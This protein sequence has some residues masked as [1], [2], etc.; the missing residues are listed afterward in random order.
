MAE[1]HNHGTTPLIWTPLESLRMLIALAWARRG[2][3]EI[4]CNGSLG[5]WVM[6]GL[7]GKARIFIGSSS[8]GKAAAETTASAL[9][10]AGM[11]PLLWSDFFKTRDRPLQELERRMVD[12]DGA[13][14]VGSADDRLV[15]RDKEYDQ[16]R[17]NVLF[18]YGLFAGRLGRHRCVLLMP[19]HPRFRI[20]SDFLGVVGFEFYTD[21]TLSAVAK[22]V[23]ERLQAA[24]AA[25]GFKPPSL[26]ERCRR[27]LLLSSWVR[28]EMMK[29][30]LNERPLREQF[31]EKIVTILCFLKEDID[32]LGLREDAT[33]LEKLVR[34]S[35]DD[36]PDL[37]DPR[38]FED[39]VKRAVRKFLL[40]PRR[41]HSLDEGRFHR[42]RHAF[43]RKIDDF[44]RRTSVCPW[45]SSLED[46]KYFR[47]DTPYLQSLLTI[48]G[49][50]YHYW[51]GREG[52]RCAGHAWHMGALDMVE[53]QHKY[54][55]RFGRKI[56]HLERWHRD[57]VP[58]ILDRLGAMEQA[59]HKQ[60]FG[61]L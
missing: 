22:K 20:P 24:F 34:K 27:L 42:L 51:G 15:S 41:H 13:I 60:I 40:H 19:D 38:S 11:R 43:G 47:E 29:A 48:G 30:K 49:S 7:D 36:F 6:R 32:E 59:V 33:E 26:Q 31:G 5:A 10:A 39:Q 35:L 50:H 52:V 58:A 2:R 46:C 45:C 16:M 61:H 53:F 9:K 57:W 8:E 21:E 3:Q 25:D 55:S 12:A 23:P 28:S 1:V 14:L 44:S 18:E 4:R 56:D 17:D 54:F 37:P